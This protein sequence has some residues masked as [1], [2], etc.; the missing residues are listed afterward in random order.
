MSTVKKLKVKQLVIAPFQ[1]VGGPLSYSTLAL[2]EDGCVYRF[3]PKCKGWLPW[4]M[5]IA[6]CIDEHPGGR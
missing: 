6:G 3:D 1:V 5:E 4:P 2:G